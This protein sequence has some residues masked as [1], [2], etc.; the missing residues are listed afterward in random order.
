MKR[1]MFLAAALALT[2]SAAIAQSDVIKQRQEAMKAAGGATATAGKMLKGDEA[3]D[4]AKAQGEFATMAA[5]IAA[6][7]KLRKK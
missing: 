3:F 6:I 4:L 2:A 5:Q 1:M 7:S